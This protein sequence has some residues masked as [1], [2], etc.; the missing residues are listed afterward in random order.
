MAYPY[1]LILGTMTTDDLIDE[2]FIAM[3]KNNDSY[4]TMD[5]LF[6]MTHASF[7]VKATEML[8]SLL[9]KYMSQVEPTLNTE[10]KRSLDEL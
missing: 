7:D 9:K 10:E 6:G 1:L 4:V 2:W 8:Q 5:E 3:D